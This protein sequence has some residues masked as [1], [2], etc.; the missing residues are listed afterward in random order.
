MQSAFEVIDSNG[1]V[2]A[3]YSGERHSWRVSRSHHGMS[4]TMDYL[5]R[6]MEDGGSYL[7]QS[8]KRTRNIAICML[9]R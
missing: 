6:V 8:A 2:V 7:R 1:Q 4:V 3:L 5:G 9:T